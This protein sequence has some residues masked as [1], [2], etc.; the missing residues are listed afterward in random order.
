MRYDGAA[1]DVRTL[2]RT[3]HR[4]SVAILGGA[5]FWDCDPDR[6]AVAFAGALDAGVDHLDVAPQYGRA[7]DLYQVHAGTDVEELGARTDA[8]GAIFAAREDGLCRNVG[9]TGHGLGAPAAHLEA[10]RRYDLDTVMFPVNPQLWSDRTYRR[11]AEALLAEAGERDV[12]VMAIKSLP[13]RPWQGGASDPLSSPSHGRAENW[14]V[15]A[16]RERCGWDTDESSKPSRTLTL[17]RPCFRA[18]WNAHTTMEGQSMWHRPSRSTTSSTLSIRGDGSPRSC[19]RFRFRH[20]EPGRNET[21]STPGDVRESA[22][23]R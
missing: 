20:L 3:G 13:A 10:L 15:W 11:D 16:S 12:G 21:V 18:W 8:L 9:I 1:V 2:G 7:E 5:A 19:G 23:R 17:E 6:A 22:A 14:E 4:S